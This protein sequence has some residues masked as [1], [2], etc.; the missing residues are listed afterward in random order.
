VNGHAPLAGAFDAGRHSPL[1]ATA[2]A[3]RDKDQRALER[4]LGRLRHR[5]PFSGSGFGTSGGRRLR[6]IGGV[7]LLVG[8]FLGFLPILGFWM[9]PLG[10]VLLAQDIPQLRKPVRRCMVIV[11][12][13]WRRWRRMR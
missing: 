3:P 1:H 13:R 2:K 11:E 7:L 5:S 10:L 8:G 9:I 12:R 6:L 4:R